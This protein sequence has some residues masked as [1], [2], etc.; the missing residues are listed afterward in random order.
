MGGTSVARARKRNY[1]KIKILNIR[2]LNQIRMTLWHQV[3]QNFDELLKNDNE[4]ETNKT[5]TGCWIIDIE[6]HNSI[7]SIL[8]CPFC[9]NNELNLV[10]D[11]RFG[12][13]SNTN[14]EVNKHYICVHS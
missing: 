12:L 1:M 4:S 8:C 7:F 6:I 3:L 11:S 2:K 13:C 14:D 10:K 5:I 9:V